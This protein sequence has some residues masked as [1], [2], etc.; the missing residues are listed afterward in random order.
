MQVTAPRL[1]EVMPL[2]TPMRAAVDVVAVLDISAS[3]TERMD[4]LKYAMLELIQ[5]LH[6]EKDRLCIISFSD[7]RECSRFLKMD[8]S[9]KL[10][11]ITIIKD[12]KA[13]G[14]SSCVGEALKD[15]AKV[16]ASQVL[17]KTISLVV[18][19]GGMNA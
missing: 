5:Q 14:N 1:R 8:G 4:G 12:L 15:A 2:Q 6:W 16:R 3:M 13:G 19:V 17:I 18:L 11:A 10:T 9:E 7:T